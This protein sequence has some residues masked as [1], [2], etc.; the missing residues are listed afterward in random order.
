M[1]ASSR[2]R[3]LQPPSQ[4]ITGDFFQPP[5][6]YLFIYLFFYFC[7]LEQHPRPMEGPRLEVELELQLPAH[8]TATAT[9]DPSLQPT[10][11]L[12]AT[13]DP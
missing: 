4:V 5:L 10:P 7:F 3:S 2:F 11:Q 12:M 6:V 13:P 8:S 9:Q 1:P